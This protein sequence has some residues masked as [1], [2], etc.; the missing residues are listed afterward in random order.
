[1]VTSTR[2]DEYETCKRRK[3]RNRLRK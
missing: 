1:M 2:F 3:Q